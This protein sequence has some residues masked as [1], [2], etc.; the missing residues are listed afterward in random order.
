VR[1][2]T[3]FHEPVSWLTRL[4]HLVT[5]ATWIRNFITSHPTYRRDS[6]VTEEINYDLAKAVDEV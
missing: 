3:S 4:G 2:E 1:G 6:V 5:P